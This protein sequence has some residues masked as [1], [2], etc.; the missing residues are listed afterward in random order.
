[1][2]DTRQRVWWSLERACSLRTGE[3][4]QLPLVT[5]QAL[6]T[7]QQCSAALNKTNPAVV[8]GIW[9]TS[10]FVGRDAANNTVYIPSSGLKIDEIGQ[11]HGGWETVRSTCAKCEANILA[12]QQLGQP[13]GTSKL[14]AQRPAMVGGCFGSIEVMY[15][16]SS[17]LDELLWKVIERYDL[18]D[19]LR[20]A[21]QLTDPLWFGF[22]MDSPLDRKQCRCLLDLLSKALPQ[23]WEKP[24][25]D[26]AA[27]PVFADVSFAFS[28]FN[29]AKT[30]G[31]EYAAFFKALEVSLQANLPLHVHIPPPGHTDMG[32]YTIFAHCPRCKAAADVPRW[33]DVQSC[34]YTCSVCG[35]SFDPASTYSR[36]TQDFDLDA[37]SLETQMGADYDA[38]ALEYARVRGYSR[39]Q[40]LE[41]L[42]IHRDGPSKRMVASTRQ[43]VDAIRKKFTSEVS[44][45]DL[46][47]LPPELFIEVAPDVVL[48]FV[49]A[50]AGEFEMGE[51][52]SA[53]RKRFFGVSDDRPD[54]SPDCTEEN[55]EGGKKDLDWC[56]SLPI[57]TV[58]FERPFYIGKF[59]ITQ[60]QWRAVMGSNPSKHRF[61]NHPVEQVNWFAAQEF[62]ARL[63]ERLGRL[64]R[65]PSEAEWEY[66][67][68][69][70]TTSRCYCGEKADSEHANLDHET[71]D[72]DFFSFRD[73]S[74]VKT[75]PVDRYPPNPWGIYDMLGNIHEWCQDSWHDNYHH[76]PADGSAWVDSPEP[77]EHVVRGGAAYVIASAC[78]SGGR[79]NQRADSG[80]DPQPDSVDDQPDDTQEDMRRHFGMNDLFGLRLVCE[81]N[82][83]DAMA[84]IAPTP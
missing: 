16:S 34:E 44:L 13:T 17:S 63:S 37:E 25:D 77:I 58:R 48:E 43:R 56:H 3:G 41:A 35:H 74:Q 11:S 9:V 2:A 40:M 4:W 30:Y 75:T 79:Y 59:P 14:D 61:P 57:H 20:D 36:E 19:Q 46:Q 6:S 45:D 67:C 66:A 52:P 42:D 47:K 24:E 73:R 84:T 26:P 21:F 1:M 49:L 68:R 33:Q 8:N 39:K 78:T 32:C 64:M 27:E 81:P 50:P 70:G 71:S 18:E 72:A 80:A 69:A 53:A 55:V 65:L 38:F 83:D 82:V 22:W 54:D 23:L 5:L 10:N 28:G 31:R 76:A 51:E 12:I 7:L 62:C 29:P 15:P 60:R